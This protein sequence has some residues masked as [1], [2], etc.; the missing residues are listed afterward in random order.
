MDIKLDIYNDEC[1]RLASSMYLKFDLLALA[2]ERWLNRSSAVDPKREN[3]LHY[4]NLAGEYHSYNTPMT[5]KSLDTFEDITF[6]RETLV[7]HPNTLA[8]YGEF[9]KHYDAL[10]DKYPENNVLIKGIIYG[11][12]KDDIIAMEDFHIVG[13]NKNLIDVQEYDLISRLNKTLTI[14]GTKVGSPGYADVENEYPTV[15]LANMAQ[16]VEPL[17]KRIRAECSNRYTACDFY[18]WGTINSV[19]N[20]DEYRP[21]LTYDDVMYL[22]KNI[23]RLKNGLCSKSVFHEILDTI[24]RPKQ[25]DAYY[26]ESNRILNSMDSETRYADALWQQRVVGGTDIK[27]Y[28]LDTVV[29]DHL[30]RSIHKVAD[31]KEHLTSEIY[32]DFNSNVYPELTLYDN[33]DREGDIRETLAR[34]D[35][36]YLFSGLGTLSRFYELVMPHNGDTITLQHNDWLIIH[37]RLVQMRTN[38]RTDTIPSH[39]TS[40][41]YKTNPVNKGELITAGMDNDTADKVIKVIGPLPVVKNDSAA[42]TGYVDNYLATRSTV[43]SLISRSYTKDNAL[44]IDDCNAVLFSSYTIRMAEDDTNYDNWLDDRG[45][46]LES[47]EDSTRN[48]LE[49]LILTSVVGVSD[50]SA[51]ALVSYIGSMLYKFLSYKTNIS[52]RMS[53]KLSLKLTD[54]PSWIADSTEISS[55]EQILPMVSNIYSKLVGVDSAPLHTANTRL[56]TCMSKK[57]DLLPAPKSKRGLSSVDLSNRRVI[58]RKSHT[59]T[60]RILEI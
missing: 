20:L 55:L 3:W 41:V 52:N 59:I 31:A 27:M 13:W 51:D 7:N 48:Q 35:Y 1:R 23:L 44:S 21:Y 14:M 43:V 30:N 36:S 22:F 56:A 16:A 15:I 2:T 4:M 19:I 39:V 9:G 24:I 53:G 11:R 34:V 10:V 57:I 60:S 47:L 46:D 32:Q 38:S 26:L 6:S 49:Y 5:I 8:L 18:I 37:K 40:M 28:N 29:E 45:F 17:I 25:I 50:D 42:I 54:R 33:S 58:T 12:S